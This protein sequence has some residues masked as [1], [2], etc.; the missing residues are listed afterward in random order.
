MKIFFVTVTKKAW[1]TR[2]FDGYR[3]KII[4]D[5]ISWPEIDRRLR[6]LRRL[7]LIEGL[8]TDERCA[9]NVLGRSRNGWKSWII[10][11]GWRACKFYAKPS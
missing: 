1:A 5:R 4:S 9:S 3:V 10:W 2:L 7:R 8:Q 6:R 11:K